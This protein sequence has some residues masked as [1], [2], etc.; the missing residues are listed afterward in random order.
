MVVTYSAEHSVGRLG[1][2][3]VMSVVVVF[4]CSPAPE[5]VPPVT[6]SPVSAPP[7]SAPSVVSDTT[8]TT[9][10]DPNRQTPGLF[11][12]PRVGDDFQIY[13]HLPDDYDTDTNTHYPVVFLLDGDWYFNGGNRMPGGVV[14]IVSSLVETGDMPPAILVGIGYSGANERGRDF[15]VSPRNFQAFLVGDLIPTIDERY[16]TVPTDRTLMGHSDGGY[17][18]VHTLLRFMDSDDPPFTKYVA[19]SG[20]YNKGTLIWDAEERLSRRSETG[21]VPTALYLGVGGMEEHGFELSNRSLADVLTERDYEYLE[22]KMRIY[23]NSHHGNVIPRAFTDGL[24][25]V[26]ASPHE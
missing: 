3:A 11:H 9:V 18:S 8:T 10:A 7:V 23:G 17:S 2:L 12:S 15:L 20:R 1:L 14:G 6:A 4:G 25:W 19:I 24:K 13:V 21:G 16:R 26:F 22:F 5:A